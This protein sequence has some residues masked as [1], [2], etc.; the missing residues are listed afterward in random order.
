VSRSGSAQSPFTIAVA[1]LAIILMTPIALQRTPTDVFP[2]IDI[3]VIGIAWQGEQVN[4]TAQ[5]PEGRSNSQG[6]QNPKQ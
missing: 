2:D 4:V 5:T 3:P 6:S 1:A